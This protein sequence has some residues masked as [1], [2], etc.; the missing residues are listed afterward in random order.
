MFGKLSSDMEN[1][2]AHGFH[3]L[4]EERMSRFKQRVYHPNLT[5]LSE[6]LES[7]FPDV[8]LDAFGIFD[9]GIMEKQSESELLARLNTLTDHF[10]PHHVIDS[11][12]T[13]PMFFKICVVYITPKGSVNTRFDV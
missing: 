10:G 5:T 1:L 13:V 6:H 4:T 9:P 3:E 11:D 8:A 7:R 12:S 2:V